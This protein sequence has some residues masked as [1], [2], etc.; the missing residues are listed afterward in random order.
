MRF[1]G[2][3]AVLILLSI[4]LVAGLLLAGCGETVLDDVKTADAIEKSLEDAQGKKVKAVECPSGVE[5]EPGTSFECSVTL[6][7]GKQETATLKIRNEDADVDLT[8]LQPDK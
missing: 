6:S 5:V 2:R 1:K 7:G 8:D 4:S 3:A